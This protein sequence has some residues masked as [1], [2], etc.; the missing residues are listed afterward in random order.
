MSEQAMPTSEV[1]IDAVAGN[2]V[3]RATRIMGAIGDFAILVSFTL[4]GG[5]IGLFLEDAAVQNLWLKPVEGGKHGAYGTEAMWICAAIGALYI[6]YKNFQGLSANGQTLMGQ[7]M[8]C[9]VVTNGGDAVNPVVTLV[10]RI[11]IPTA[12]MMYLLIEGQWLAAAVFAVVV[13]G[14]AVLGGKCL[15]DVATGTQVVWADN[16]DDV[17]SAIRVS[18]G[19]K[20]FVD[21]V[22]R[23]G[24]WWI[25]PVV[26]ITCFDVIARKAVWE[27]SEGVRVGIQI[28]LVE[29]FGRMFDS[30]LL[31][32]MEWHSHTI[33]FAFVLAYG[34]IHNTHVRVD[35]LRE[36]F[37]FRTKAMLEFI[38]LT[39]FLIPYCLIVAYFALEYAVD[40][41]AIAEIS[42]S[43]VGLP[44]RWVIKT[45]LMFGLLMVV[46]AGIS[47]WLQVVVALWGPQGIRFPL[48]TIEWPEDAGSTIEGK[49]RID[50]NK[51]EDQLEK[52]ARESGH[53]K[54]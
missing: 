15:H 45:L 19:L 18:E 43:Q 27:N 47:V 22:G 41:Y 36:R 3:P 1:R 39:F 28:W 51:V 29:N 46:A 8:S 53:L 33:L 26:I 12:V 2:A 24:S 9:R 35:L 4:F 50:L 7:M 20:R 31:Q 11:G 23:F 14:F 37:E 5:F 10:V 52:R 42:A 17:P 25:V 30:T 38:G 6:I 34:Y 54:D 49:E 48:M 16:A 32:E 21:R 44:M 40:S 13:V